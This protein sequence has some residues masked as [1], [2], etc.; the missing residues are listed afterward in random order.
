LL[1][2]S[3]ILEI[4]STNLKSF[5]IH[6]PPLNIQNQIVE[7]VNQKENLINLLKENMNNAISQA[8][9]IMSQLFTN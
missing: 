8:N 4:N 2:G 3:T 6:I 9:D 1:V 7:Q 5:K